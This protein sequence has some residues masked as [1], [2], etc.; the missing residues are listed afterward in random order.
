MANHSARFVVYLKWFF[1]AV[2]GTTLFLLILLIVINLPDEELLPEAQAFR[3]LPLI[4]ISAADNGYIYRMGFDAPEGDDPARFGQERIDRLLA[5][6]ASGSFVDS[7]NGNKIEFHGNKG[8]LCS[9]GPDSSCLDKLGDKAL[10][11]ST[12]NKN[13]ELLARYTRL[14]RYKAAI[15]DN[16]SV[17][18]AIW[19]VGP[20]RLAQRLYLTKTVLEWQAGNRQKAI[21]LLVADLNFWRSNMEHGRSLIDKVIATAVIRNALQVF[22]EFA[23]SENFGSGLAETALKAVPEFSEQ[24]LDMSLAWQSEFAMGSQAIWDDKPTFGTKDSWFDLLATKLFFK[25]NATLNDIYRVIRLN[26]E[27]DR[28]ILFGD[29]TSATEHY[30][31]T[32]VDDDL[33]GI[34]YNPMGKIVATMMMRDEGESYAKRSKDTDLL[35]KEI[36]KRLREKVRR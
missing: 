29:N 21:E 9:L 32:D 22:D 3:T 12:L 30:F 8:H 13:R 16:T 35:L 5:A 31:D 20:V 4:P 24:E 25:P 2:T 26:I 36:R 15:Q 27:N 17:N 23:Q 33:L 1:L 14:I 7:E 34:L 18:A 11:E 19:R 6:K 28:R 10:I